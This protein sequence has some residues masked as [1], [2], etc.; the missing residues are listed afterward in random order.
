MIARPHSISDKRLVSATLS[1]SHDVSN[2]S[3][4]YRSRTLQSGFFVTYTNSSLMLLKHRQ[5]GGQQRQ[6]RR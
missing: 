4:K 5:E 6:W 2:E 1:E 3:R